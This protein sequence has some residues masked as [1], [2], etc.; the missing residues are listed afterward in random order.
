MLDFSGQLAIVTGGTRG[1]GAAISRGLLERGARVVATYAGDEIS[2]AALKESVG[3]TVAQRLSF[4]CFDVSDYAACDRFF[5]GLDRPPEILVN[6]AGIRRD[7]VV[8]ML[9]W[10]DWRRVI[11]VNLDG[12][13]NM[14]KLAVMAM[15]R[16]RY[17]RIINITSIAAE[18][19]LKGQANYAAS[20]AGQT[21]LCR[22][23]AKEVASR[24]ITVNCV[25]PGFIETDMLN[26]L[27]PKLVEEYKKQVPAGRFGLPEE[28]ASAVLFLASKSASY[29]TGSSLTVAGGL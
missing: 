28:V 18:L 2:A 29:I 15:L 26:G 8:G 5:T 16:Q 3:P 25:E 12:A 7:A 6:N 17:G 27:D 1:I 19:A 22:S 14:S 23:L 4:A 10:E 24:N 20:K 21:A 11:A 13:F 9:K